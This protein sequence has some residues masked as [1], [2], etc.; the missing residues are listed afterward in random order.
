MEINVA[1]GMSMAPLTL[2]DNHIKTGLKST[3]D[4]GLQRGKNN[5]ERVETIQFSHSLVIYPSLQ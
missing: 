3:P 1:E 4:L 2:G 5:R